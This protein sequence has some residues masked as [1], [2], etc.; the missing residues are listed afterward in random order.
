MLFVDLSPSH[1]RS[2]F[3]GAWNS[4]NDINTT[5]ASISPNKDAPTGI[6]IIQSR[7]MYGSVKNT[8]VVAREGD[9]FET[10]LHTA[11]YVG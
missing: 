10:R 2:W 9:G 7:T 8:L 11:S 4:N 6:F 5:I 1:S 3:I